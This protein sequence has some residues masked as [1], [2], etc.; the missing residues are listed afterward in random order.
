MSLKFWWLQN[1]KSTIGYANVCS[2]LEDHRL[3]FK[4]LNQ[5]LVLKVQDSKHIQEH[6]K[7]IRSR[8]FGS[9]SEEDKL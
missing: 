2:N 5:V 9:N 1:I 3:K 7:L 4:V 8:R 6:F